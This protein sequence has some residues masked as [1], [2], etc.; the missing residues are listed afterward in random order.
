M[1]SKKYIILIVIF[2]YLSFSFL[3]KKIIINNMSIIIKY[4]PK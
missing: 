2:L 3:N 1:K 4:I